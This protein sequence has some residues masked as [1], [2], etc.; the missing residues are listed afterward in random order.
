MAYIT[1]AIA[2]RKGEGPALVDETGTTSWADFDARVNQVVERDAEPWPPARRHRGLAVWQPPGVLRGDGGGRARRVGRRPRQLALGGRRAGLCARRLRRRRPLRRGRYAAVAAE[3][4]ADDRAARCTTRIVIGDPAPDGFAPYEEFLAG[5]LVRRTRR[6][7]SGGPMFYTSGTTGFPKGVRSS[8]TATGLDPEVVA[9]VAQVAVGMLHIPTD[10]VTLLEGPAYHSA[11][12]AL[13]V[14]PLLG[15]AST[16]VMR[17]HFDPAETLALIDRYQVTNIHLVPTQFIRFLKLPD[18][19]R[20]GFDGGSLVS[21]VHGAAPCPVEVKQK[22]LDWWGPVITEYYGGTEGG[23]LT[24]VTGEEWQAR[25]GTLGRP[26]NMTELMIVGDDG[27]A[28]PPVN[29]A[30]STSRASSGPTSPTT[31]RR[32]RPRLPTWLRASAPWVTSATSTTTATSS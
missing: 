21:V 14:L 22:M 20:A 27:T 12:W 2:E 16:V 3:A 10:G 5:G 29:R 6:S 19:V 4:C 13:S 24:V 25:P 7:V 1:R 23:F 32:R 30:R 31:R 8:V 11:Q 17:H 18:E 26:T 9:L 15:A 28:A